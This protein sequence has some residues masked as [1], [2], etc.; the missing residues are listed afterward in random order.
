MTHAGVSA[1]ARAHAR[2]QSCGVAILPARQP[3][4]AIEIVN[5][6]RQSFA[7]SRVGERRLARTR[8]ADHQDAAHRSGA[9]GARGLEPREVVA[10]MVRGA[11]QRRGRHHQEALGVGDGLVGLELVGRARSASTSWCLRVGCRYW[12]MVRK[13][14]SA[15]R[16]SSISCSTSFRSSPSPTMMPDLVNI[17]RIELLHLLQQADRGEVARARPHGE[18]L[19]RHGFEIVVEHV[20][21]RRDH[22]LDR[23]VL[24]QEVRRQHLDGGLR[25]R[26]ADRA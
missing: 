23:A 15:A 7:A 6:Q 20:G 16:R 26:G 17:V 5:R 18:I 22:D 13:S 3:V 24:A 8:R 19:R 21:P 4:M 10:R 14:T 1:S 11:R 9:L 12:P 2:A 25:G